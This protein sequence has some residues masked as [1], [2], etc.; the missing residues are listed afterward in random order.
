MGLRNRYSWTMATIAIAALLLTALIS[1]NG[2]ADDPPLNAPPALPYHPVQHAANQHPPRALPPQQSPYHQVS[3]LA[4][5]QP[6]TVARAIAPRP[7]ALSSVGLP[8]GQWSR[9][10]ALGKVKLAIS[11]N[12][13]A[14][15][16]A[17]SGDFAAFNPSLRGEYAVASDGTVFG[18][19]HS[20]DLGVSALASQ[21]MGEEL[22]MFNS[23]SDIPFS[24]RTYAEPDVL[25]VKQVTF[26]LPIQLVMATDGDTGELSVYVQSML[27][28]QYE[29]SR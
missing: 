20:V 1:E 5:R 15:D 16:V 26:G 29:S 7:N 21:E 14:V 10:T 2:G 19:I 13:I 12:K 27:T 3:T 28:G 23:M 4:D 6:R 17:G 24:M 11:G 9:D 22:M 18:L 8:E 25:A